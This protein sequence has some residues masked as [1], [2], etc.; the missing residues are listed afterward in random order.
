MEKR[1]KENP[2]DYYAKRYFEKK[3]GAKVRTCSF[4]GEQGHNK[5]TCPKKKEALAQ[6][7]KANR[8]YQEQVAKVFEEQGIKVGALVVHP[9]LYIKG[10]YVKD[11]VGVVTG[12]DWDKIHLWNLDNDAPRCLNVRFTGATSQTATIAPQLPTTHA[13]L[14]WDNYS[15]Y[16]LPIVSP[17]SGSIGHRRVDGLLSKPAMKELLEDD[18]WTSRYDYDTSEYRYLTDMEMKCEKYWTKLNEKKENK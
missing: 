15:S 13:A 6:F 11:V 16:C 5:A 1:I 12:I 18:K 2:D 3:K 17:G 7:S 9:Q 8:H 14:N 10:S 4:C